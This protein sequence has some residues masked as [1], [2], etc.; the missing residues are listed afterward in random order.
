MTTKERKLYPYDRRT[1]IGFTTS[2]TA[3]VIANAFMSSY[4]LLYLTDY[5]GLGKLG[6]TI[7]PIILVIGRIVDA[8]NDPLQGLIVDSA[9]PT[10]F[11]KYKFFTLLSILLSTLS[12]SFLYSIPDGI[13]SSAPMLF[14]WILLFYLVYDIGVSFYSGNPLLQSFGSTEVHRAKLSTYQRFNSITLGAVFSVFMMVVNRVNA[15]VGNFGKAFSYSAIGFAAIAC[16]ISLISLSLVREGKSGETEH[17]SAE[18]LKLKNFI[19]IF[20]LN[21]ALNVHFFAQ[22]CRGL[23]FAMMMATTAYYIKWAF[24][25]DLATGVFDAE[26]LGTYTI[27]FMLGSMLPMMIAAAVSPL[28]TRKMGSGL[29]LITFACYLTSAAGLV[30]FVLQLAGV[31]HLNFFLFLAT[32]AVLA[33]GNGLCFVPTNT[34]WI[35]CMDYNAYVTGKSMAGTINSI[36]SFINKAQG[37]LATAL[38]GLLLAFIG[39]N[40]DSVTG[41]YV[42][43]L[44]NM[45]A[46]LTGFI[47]VCAL[48]PA[49]FAIMAVLIYRK[50]PITAEVKAKMNAALSRE[51]QG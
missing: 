3:Q 21:K 20:R 6:A 31:L 30:M 45:P 5:A 4:F 10:R 13:K 24:C 42:G 44:A 17:P 15:V 38:T 51:V 33:F 41:D 46:M 37:A 26:K 48:L 35:E 1:S 9:K 23:V 39:Y 19:D 49:I 14:V 7:A 43:D 36:F 11:G 40:V 25:A 16:V 28:L 27:I 22:L 8:V 18:K 12:I 50:Y 2:N 29:K 34:L 47:A 32:F